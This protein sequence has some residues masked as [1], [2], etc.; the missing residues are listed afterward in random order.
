M[1]LLQQ[2]IELVEVNSFVAKFGFTFIFFLSMLTTQDRP[3]HL[4][5]LIVLLSKLTT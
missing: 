5:P 3:D 1:I 4:H 2:K